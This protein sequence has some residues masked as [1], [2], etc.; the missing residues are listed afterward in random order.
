MNK[1]G[2]I[3]HGIPHQPLHRTQDIG[4]GRDTHGILLIIGEN[5]HIPPTIAK[6]LMKKDR[7]VSDIVDAAMQLV[8]LAEVVDANEEGTTA[9]G[10]GRVAEVVVG[11]GTLAEVLGTLGRGRREIR[12][13]GSCFFLL[14]TLSYSLVSYFMQVVEAYC[15]GGGGGARG[16]AKAAAAEDAAMV[17]RNNPEEEEEDN[18]SSIGPDTTSREDTW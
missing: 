5:D 15:C 17:S 6:L 18:H 14:S 7:H 12:G 11:G 13:P 16:M 1:Q 8:G 10:A 9:A 4:L 3:R 2:I